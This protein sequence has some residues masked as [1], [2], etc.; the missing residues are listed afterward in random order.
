MS[1]KKK[2]GLLASSAAIALILAACGGDTAGEDTGTDDAGSEDTGTENGASEENGAEDA[3]GGFEATVENEGEAIDGGTLHIGLVAE[4]AF[5]GIFSSEFYEIDTDSQVMGPQAGSVLRSD[6]N[7]QWVDGAASMEYDQESNVVTL[8][9]Q[10][11]VMWHPTPEGDSEELTA[12]DILFTHEIIGDPDYDGVR[13]GTS[14]QNI[15]GMPEFKAGEA[16][17]I[18]GM[19]LVDDYTLEIQYDQPL[20]PSVYQAG[21][22]VWAYAAPRHYYGD[23]EVTE[24][25]SSPQIRENPIGFGPFQVTNIVPGESVEYEAFEDYYEG[26][27]NM[28]SIILERVPVSGIVSS[29]ES[30]D[31]DVTLNMPTSEYESFQDGI[32]GYTTLGS[33]GQSYD[34]ISFKMGEWDPEANDG[35]GANVYDPDAKMSDL[36]LRKAMAHA[37]DVDRVGEE[38]Y[39]G[40]R[41]RA[42]SHIVPNFGDFYDDSLEGYPYDP[43]T[44][45]QLLDEAGYEDVD[46]DGVR[47]DPNGEELT[48]N[49]AAR[50]GS[51]AAEPIALYFLSA[52]EEIGLDVQLM[53][54]RLHEVNTFYDRVQADDEE[55]DVFEGGWVVGSDPNPEGLYGENAA[56]NF[57]RFVSDENN[58]FFAD[59]SSE[60]AFETD[61][62]I[63]VFHE[64]QDYFMNDALPAIPTF[65]RTELQLVN[66]RVSNWSHASV[67]GADPATYG[68]HSIELLEEN[69]VTE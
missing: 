1:F 8:T 2:Y 59:M 26:A 6:E 60:E 39:H 62:Q 46:D 37:I 28:D 20:G 48:I 68:Y 7:Y 47:E 5:P 30:G 65:W 54:D 33:P 3:R 45:N 38:F 42:D 23:L 57:S 40:L 16:D 32:P 52:W 35:S 10:E 36:N 61:Y 50:A 58:Q 67:P 64:W 29:L 43:D 4:S 63:E 55:I 66:D 53:E 31:F 25:A 11:G 9:V 56:F 13:Y 18:S 15:V 14:F 51:D 12:D 41:Y 19:T 27:P 49:Y 21:G 44:A 34:Y 17:E 69:P 24:I 22:P